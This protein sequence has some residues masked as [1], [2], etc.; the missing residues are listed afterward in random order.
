MWDLICTYKIPTLPLS[1]DVETKSVLKKLAEARA[2]I[3]ELNGI[4]QLIPQPNI[5]INTL[6]LQEAKD[7]SAIENIITT[8]DEL[9]KADINIWK[10]SIET[11]EVKDYKDALLLGFQIVKKNKMLLI[12]DIRDVQYKIE[13]N[14]AGVRKSSWT[15]LKSEQTNEITYIPPQNYEDIMEYLRDLEQYINTQDEI[16]PLIKLAIIHHQFE[17]IHPFSDGNG[18]TWRIINVLCLILTDLL[19]LP[20]LYLSWYIIKTKSEYYKLLQDVRD[21]GNREPWLLY[22][23]DSVEKTAK[24]TTIMIKEIWD[25]MWEVKHK[26]KWEVSFYSKDLLEILFK[27]PYTKIEFLVDELGVVRQTASKYLQELEDIG[28]L[29]MIKVK[30]EKFYVNV[31][32][33]EIFRV[34]LRL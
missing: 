30:K 15:V 8:H 27:H 22:M 5:L 9:Y 24:S 34:W 25:L 4:I 1:I 3:A 28:V 23:L 20:V 32:L 13:H 19:D 18:R 11:K 33:Y 12:N 29:H 26:I 10:I 2:A 14:D 17:S 7:S 6:A 31:A 16:D 21:T